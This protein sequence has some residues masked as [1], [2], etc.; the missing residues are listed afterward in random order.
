MIKQKPDLLVG[1]ASDTG[2]KRKNNEDSFLIHKADYSSQNK[3]GP[4]LFMVADGIGGSAAGEVAS[5]IAVEGVMK[6]YRDFPAMNPLEALQS[7]IRDAHEKIN[8]K[9]L[10]FPEYSGMGST[11]TVLVLADE[12][13]YIGQIGDSRAY[14]IRERK[15]AQLTADQT[16]TADLLA[17]GKITPAEAETHPQR[18]ILIQAMGGG[19]KAPEPDLMSFAVKAGDTLVLCTDGL[20]NLVSDDEIKILAAQNNPQS[21]SEQLVN[22]ANERGGNDNITV[23]IIKVTRF[24]RIRRLRRVLQRLSPN[25]RSIAAVIGAYLGDILSRVNK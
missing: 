20:Y 1:A 24:H 14:L 7:A 11:L 3:T 13:V 12:T 16:V 15:I 8:A 22:L 18:H 4:S 5:K 25:T 2:K 23:V 6:T 21:S 19:R 10:E 17:K 9:A